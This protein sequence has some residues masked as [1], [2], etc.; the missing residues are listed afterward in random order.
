MGKTALLEYL[1]A[2]ASGFRTLWAS[3]VES[4]MELV[5]AGLHQI[6]APMLG[7]VGHLPS[8]QRDALS[9]AFGLSAGPA[10]DRFLIGRRL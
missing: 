6:C 2:H 8:P 4:E 3:G 7:Q 10:P 1:I 9:V 5:F